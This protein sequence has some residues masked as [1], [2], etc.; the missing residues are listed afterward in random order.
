MTARR[1]E[2]PYGM[3]G[4]QWKRRHH[5][6]PATRHCRTRPWGTISDGR[7]YGDSN[8]RK[9][10]EP[11]ESS[12]IF[13]SAVIV[14]HLTLSL[15]LHLPRCLGWYHSPRLPMLIAAFYYESLRVR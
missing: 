14:A 6:K 5:S 12:T 1:A 2:P 11:L 9:T 8:R 13:E 4:G 3:I 7:P 10:Q 15:P